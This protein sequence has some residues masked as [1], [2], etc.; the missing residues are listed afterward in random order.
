MTKRPI[1]NHLFGLLAGSIGLFGAASAF[2]EPICRPALAFRD[3]R[4]SPMRPPSLARTWTAVLAVDASRCTATSGRFSV[5]FER[6]KENAPD[7]A[8]QEQFTWRPETTE[9]SL[10]VS[11]DETVERYWLGD[12]AACPCRD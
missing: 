7:L 3:V 8:F 10:D 5:V 2:A 9:V 1:F 12:V 11:A 6:L 4:L